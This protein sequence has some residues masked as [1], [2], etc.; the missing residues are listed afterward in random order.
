MLL[1]ADPEPVSKAFLKTFSR[2]DAKN[3]QRLD[4]NTLHFAP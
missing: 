2:N 3:T 1:I 4:I